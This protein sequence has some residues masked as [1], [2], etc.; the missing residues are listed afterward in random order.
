MWEQHDLISAFCR[1]CCPVGFIK[2]MPS[3]CTGVI[4]SLVW[5]GWDETQ[6]LQIRGHSSQPEKGGLIERS[7]FK[8]KS[9][10]GS[11]SRLGE[12]WSIRLTGRLVQPQQLCGRCIRPLC[13]LKRQQS[14]FT[15]QSMLLFSAVMN[16]GEWPDVQECRYKSPKWVSSAGWICGTLG[17]GWEV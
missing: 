8:W 4:C 7:C 15:G 12:R 3:A 17:I 14:Q 1:W 2:P 10:S 13:W 11:C 9:I 5:C 16:F 6:H